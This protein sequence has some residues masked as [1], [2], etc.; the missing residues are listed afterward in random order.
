M[1]GKAGPHLIP[2]LHTKGTSF[3]NDVRGQLR[4]N[5]LETAWGQIGCLTGSHESKDNLLLEFIK[6]SGI[7][8]KAGPL[9]NTSSPVAH[10]KTGVQVDESL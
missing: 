6:P 9:C 3:R 1:R 5:S 2:P 7:Y 10:D 8:F 4:E